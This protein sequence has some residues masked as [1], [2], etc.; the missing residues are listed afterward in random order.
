MWRVWAEVCFW[1]AALMCLSPD[2][3]CD[4]NTVANVVASKEAIRT[5]AFNR[6]IVLFLVL[7]LNV[8][9]GSRFQ[10]FIDTE[11]QLTICESA[12]GRRYCPGTSEKRKQILAWETLRRLRLSASLIAPSAI[13]LLSSSEKPIHP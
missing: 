4:K 7:V 11:P 5:S 13:S 6:F 8:L 2:S 3:A 12:S 9:G 10:F 1:C